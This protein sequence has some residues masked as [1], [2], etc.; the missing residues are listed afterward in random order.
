MGITGIWRL[1]RGLPSGYVYNELTELVWVSGALGLFHA[2]IMPCLS[3][4]VKP[5]QDSN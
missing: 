5:G 4:Q 1:R 2:H 3:G